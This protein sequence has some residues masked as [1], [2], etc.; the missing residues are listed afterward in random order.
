MAKLNLI[1][2][3]S[4]D[5]LRAAGIFFVSAGFAITLASAV[6]EG[7]N[8]PEATSF[9]F[10]GIGLISLGIG[11]IAVG[12][13]IES[14]AL[15][16]ESENRMK[17]IANLEYKEK[18]GIKWKYLSDWKS[19]KLD[20]TLEMVEYYKSIAEAAEELEDWVDTELRER[21]IEVTEAI[22]KWLDEHMID[23]QE[24]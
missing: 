9:L 23:S 18:I 4:P 21:M 3:L 13:G 24:H 8:N 5:G 20:Y 12:L 11:L 14:K 6:L 10:G 16:K 2:K 22:Q 17:A 1:D 15:S 19:G 7:I